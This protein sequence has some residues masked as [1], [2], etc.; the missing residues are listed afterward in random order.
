MFQASLGIFLISFGAILLAIVIYRPKTQELERYKKA[1]EDIDRIAS[2]YLE[3]GR[4]DAKPVAA[5]VYIQAERA[6]F[7]R[8]YNIEQLVK[9]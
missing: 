2:C 4:T 7:G 5:Q 9:E 8:E 3:N 1:L 6:L